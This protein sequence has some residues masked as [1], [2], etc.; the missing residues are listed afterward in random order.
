ME[1]GQD[2][3]IEMYSA[4]EDPFDGTIARGSPSLEAVLRA[5]GVTDV[6]VAGLAGD[7]CVKET[8]LHCGLKGFR[9]WVVREGVASVDE[10]EDGWG[11]SKRAMEAVGG[12]GLVEVVGVDSLEVGWVRQLA[13]EGVE[14]EGEGDVQGEEGD[15]QKLGEKWVGDIEHRRLSLLAEGVPEKK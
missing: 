14:R 6:Y 9:T 15:L 2:P 8:V 12:G 3:R 10:G 7:Y 5:N 4:F 1:K 11:Q 13:L